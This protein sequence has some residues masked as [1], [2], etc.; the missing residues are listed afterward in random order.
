[1]YNVAK[2]TEVLSEGLE[3]NSKLARYY[4]N[5]QKEK[6]LGL[7]PDE[8]QGTHEVLTELLRII[9]EADVEALDNF[10]K[11]QEMVFDVL[12]YK[13]Q[14]KE[15]TDN[16]VREMIGDVFAEMKEESRIN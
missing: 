10:L 5:C 15:L 14:A 7:V 9:L 11:G 2:L 12:G 3:F 6:E 13:V 8:A 1:M 4:E 16:D